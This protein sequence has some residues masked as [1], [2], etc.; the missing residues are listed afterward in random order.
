MSQRQSFGAEFVQRH[1]NMR[2][3]IVRCVAPTY[4]LPNLFCLIAKICVNNGPGI[5]NSL[6]SPRKHLANRAR[7]IS[8]TFVDCILALSSSRLWIVSS[9]L[10]L[11]YSQNI[12]SLSLTA[13][14]LPGTETFQQGCE[15]VARLS[16]P[17]NPFQDHHIW[18]Y[19]ANRIR[20]T[21]SKCWR[22]PCV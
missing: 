7:T 14:C 5:S 15:G 17:V 6:A 1:V 22:G 8:E 3:S 20:Y 4:L 10:A 21:A 12:A 19:C 18:D 2:W 9:L 16:C 11:S 13:T